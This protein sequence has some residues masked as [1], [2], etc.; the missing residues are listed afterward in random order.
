MANN[1]NNNIW[2]DKDELSDG[3]KNM[4]R[5]SKSPRQEMTSYGKGGPKRGFVTN[6]KGQAAMN[7]HDTAFTPSK[8]AKGVSLP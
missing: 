5:A 7:T 1:S 6:P 2:S 3:S 8:G 4:A